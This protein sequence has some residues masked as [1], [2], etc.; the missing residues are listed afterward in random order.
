MQIIEL[1]TCEAQSRFAALPR[2]LQLQS[3]SPQFAAAD[4]LRNAELRC[5]HVVIE[6]GADQWL[7]SLHVR[8]L[9]LGECYGAQSPYGYGGVLCTTRDP[10]FLQAAWKN[11]QQWCVSRSIVAEFCR[12]HPHAVDLACFGGVV[13]EN[14]QTVSVDLRSPDYTAQF[15]A[16][17]QRKI[18]KAR[19]VEIAWSQAA[20][21]WACFA[22]FYRQ[23]MLT[24]QAEPF[25]LFPDAYFEAISAMASA[26]LVI[27]RL[28]GVWLSAGAYFLGPELA[29]YHLGA[30]APEG[31][32]LGTPYQMQAAAMQRARASGAHSLYLAGGTDPSPDN[33][34][35]FYKRSFSRRMLPF[36]V[37]EAILDAPRY[38]ALAASLGFTPAAA[39][40]RIFFD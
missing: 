31:L 22:R 15:S 16:M 25:Y 34:L 8:A 40:T 37:G 29:E 17:A 14:R 18:R 32:A 1:S 11:W 27:C 35:L 28:D 19:G 38:W 33:S 6:A 13:R 24:M 26:W 21:D 39:P 3:L 5:V 30:S 7:K 10:D 36:F 9:P 12:F 4:A 20:R 23:A 2:G